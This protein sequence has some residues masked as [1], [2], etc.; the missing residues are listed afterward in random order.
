MEMVYR[1]EGRLPGLT[2]S[3]LGGASGHEMDRL[4]RHAPPGT[5]LLA[6]GLN[7]ENG[8]AER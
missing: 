4:S 1:P 8:G 3:A 5:V 7:P 2:C 6:K